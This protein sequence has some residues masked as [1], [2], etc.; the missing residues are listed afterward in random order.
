MSPRFTFHLKTAQFAIDFYGFFSPCVQTFFS[1]LSVFIC[2]PHANRK[3]NERSK[4]MNDS[5]VS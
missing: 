5:V 3:W 4:K 1:A 2:I